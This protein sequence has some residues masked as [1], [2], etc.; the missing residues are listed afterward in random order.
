MKAIYL[1]PMLSAPHVSLFEVNLFHGRQ[2]RR[3]PYRRSQRYT[4][5][6]ELNHPLYLVRDGSHVPDVFM[7]ANES[8]TLVV[9]EKVKRQLEGLPKVGFFPVH[10][11]KLVDGSSV[12]AEQRTSF[13]NANRVLRRLPHVPALHAR[14]ESYYELIF[15]IH[16]FEAVAWEDPLEDYRFTTRPVIGYEMLDDEHYLLDDEDTKSHETYVDIDLSPAFLQDNPILWRYAPLFSEQAFALIEPYLERRYWG[17]S[18]VEVS[19]V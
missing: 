2:C 11:V 19:S 8:R 7:P 6:E 9:S 17:M 1:Y 14:L 3:E 10:F 4:W 12:P 15:P 5:G 16:T 13:A 18:E